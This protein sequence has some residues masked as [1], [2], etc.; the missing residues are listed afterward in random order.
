MLSALVFATFWMGLVGG[1]HCVMMCGAACAGISQAGGK[2]SLLQ[3]H[4]GRVLGYALLGGLAA[5]SMQG[6]GWLTIQSAALRPIWSLVH[7]AAMVLG[8]VLVIHGRQ[9]I[10][11]E[12]SARKLWSQVRTLGL[13]QGD[14]KPLVLGVCWA[15]LPCGL[16]YS[17]LMVA[18]LAPDYWQGGLAMAAFALGTTLSMVLGPWLWLRVLRGKFVQG[19]WGVRLAGLILSATAAGALW[20]GLAHQTAPWCVGP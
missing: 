7:V 8:L 18:A 4:L 1:P 19:E 15:L 20:M 12:Q 16:L 13:T 6:L 17:A 5:A 11:L 9:P 14:G 2:G 10:W 3:F